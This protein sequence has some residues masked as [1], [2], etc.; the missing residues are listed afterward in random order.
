MEDNTR[1]VWDPGLC[2]GWI[3]EL[4]ETLWGYNVK[5]KEASVVLDGVKS[6]LCICKTSPTSLKAFRLLNIIVKL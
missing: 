1:L 6:T 3:E 4:K 5:C 2:G